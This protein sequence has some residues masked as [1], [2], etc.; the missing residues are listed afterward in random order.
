LY[1]GSE[2]NGRIRYLNLSRALSIE[3]LG[4]GFASIE[5]RRKSGATRRVMKING[6]KIDC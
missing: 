6:L 2:K 4:M 3:K 1:L 5:R